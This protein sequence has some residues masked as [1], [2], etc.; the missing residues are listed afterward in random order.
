[1]SNN[2]IYHL[3]F[4]VPMM[5]REGKTITGRGPML[6]PQGPRTGIKDNP[7]DPVNFTASYVA[8]TTNLWVRACQHAQNGYKR[9]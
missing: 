5:Y 3:S 4:A 8:I 9:M 1:M 2:I 7:N 6:M